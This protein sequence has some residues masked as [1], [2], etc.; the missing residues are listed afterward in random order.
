MVGVVA[1][2]ELVD[3]LLIFCEASYKVRVAVEVE[4][5]GTTLLRKS[6]GGRSHQC[7]HKGEGTEEI[8]ERSEHFWEGCRCRGQGVV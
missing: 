3:A 7:P 1:L 4:C 2:G 8:E 6:V 5:E